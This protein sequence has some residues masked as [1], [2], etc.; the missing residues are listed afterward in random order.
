MWRSVEKL[1]SVSL[2]LG[3]KNQLCLWIRY[4]PVGVSALYR[5][6]T[7]TDGLQHHDKLVLVVPPQQMRPELRLQQATLLKDF[8]THPDVLYLLDSVGRGGLVNED[9][10]TVGGTYPRTP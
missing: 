4:I 8:I 9:G 6:F 2:A 3:D 10:C 5:N 1:A 7:E